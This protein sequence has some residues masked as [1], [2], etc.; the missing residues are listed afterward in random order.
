MI[1]NVVRYQPPR[2]WGVLFIDC[3]NVDGRNDDFYHRAIEQLKNFSISSTVC[4]TLDLKIDYEDVS[5][6][7]TL[8]RYLWNPSNINAQINQRVL[9]DLITAAGQQQTSRVLRN[10]VFNNETVCLYKRETFN[11]H[12]MFHCEGIHD[13]IIV[14]S[15]WKMCVHHGPLGVDR[16]VDIGDHKFY[17]FP[18]WSIQTEQGLPPALQD[19]HDDFYVWAPID[20]GGYRLITRAQ[21][22]KWFDGPKLTN[23]G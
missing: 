19:I 18:E 23:N 22:H 12:A 7:N 14:G 9:Q 21:N 2:H 3:W 1:R 4:C 10:N 8:Q 15:A 17:I 6:Y 11:H 13:W 16:L 5:V 20:D